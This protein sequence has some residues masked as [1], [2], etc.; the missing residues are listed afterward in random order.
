MIYIYMVGPPCAGKTE[1]AK[2]TS[3][4]VG[5]EY[6]STGDIARQHSDPT[7]EEHMREGDLA[8]EN[9]MDVLVM[10]E[11]VDRGTRGGGAI[12]VDGY[13]RYME[14]L[15]DIYNFV[16]GIH[17][18]FLITAS[19]QTIEARA[20]ARQREGDDKH[21]ARMRVWEDR[22]VPMVDWMRSR[23]GVLTINN[24]DHGPVDDHVTFISET[25][26]KRILPV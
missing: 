5:W 10:T 9:V 25:I 4:G 12:L 23:G 18:F 8:P 1:I 20:L 6:L 24:N 11:L 3:K 26:V 15:L 14:Q 19:H 16:D 22:T 2:A 7:W 13:P 17:F 21:A